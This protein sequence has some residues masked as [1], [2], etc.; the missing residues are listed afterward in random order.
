[1]GGPLKALRFDTSDNGGPLYQNV[2][3]GTRKGFMVKGGMTEGNRIFH[4]TMFGNSDCDL[5]VLDEE[6]GEGSTTP[7]KKYNDKSLVFNNAVDDWSDIN[8]GKVDCRVTPAC[9]PPCKSVPTPSIGEEKSGHATT[10]HPSPK[11]SPTLPISCSGQLEQ[12]W[13]EKQTRAMDPIME[14]GQTLALT[15]RMKTSIGCPDEW[16]L[17]QATQFHRMAHHTARLIRL[18]RG[19]LCLRK[20]DTMCTMFM[21]QR[22][23][24]RSCVRHHIVVRTREA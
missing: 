10:I 13:L 24:A 19:S 16:A 23:F 21:H 11:C 4:N 20:R 17:R 12:P 6:K 9:K 7:G 2:F 1:M 14:V 8:S 3:W 15:R 5:S 22:P 18:L